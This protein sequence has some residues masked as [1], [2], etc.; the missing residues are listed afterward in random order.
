MY[1]QMCV[2]TDTPIHIMCVWGM[3]GNL[4]LS[5]PIL[6]SMAVPWVPGGPAWPCDVQVRES[7]SLGPGVAAPIGKW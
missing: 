2:Q 1:V 5:V 7:Q 6:H 3:W 4:N